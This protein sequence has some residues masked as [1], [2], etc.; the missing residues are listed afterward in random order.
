[1][2]CFYGEFAAEIGVGLYQSGVPTAA[3]V[4]HG[5]PQGGVGFLRTFQAVWEKA[6][7]SSGVIVLQRL[8]PLAILLGAL[9]SV[10]I[11]VWSDAGLPRLRKLQVERVEAQER[12]SRLS[13]DIRRLRA[14]V[15]RVKRDPSH[16]ERTARDELGLVRQTEIVFQFQR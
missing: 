8:L 14:E 6:R 4:P 7:V 11:L 1:V 12:V 16:V 2:F 15:E 9:V 13:A 10:P 3:K 5:K